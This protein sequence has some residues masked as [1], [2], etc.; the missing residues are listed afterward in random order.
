MVHVRGQWGGDLKIKEEIRRRSEVLNF[1]PHGVVVLAHDEIRTC[2]CQVDK[3]ITSMV[4]TEVQ[5]KDMFTCD[6][7]LKKPGLVKYGRSYIIIAT[8]AVVL[9]AATAVIFRLTL[10][11]K[12]EGLDKI[13]GVLTGWSWSLAL[14]SAL[15][16]I[17]TK[18]L[19]PGTTLRNL[20]QGKRQ[21]SDLTDMNLGEG[22][23]ILFAQDARTNHLWA[24][25]NACAYANRPCGTV[26]VSEMPSG[27]S[28]S[29]KLGLFITDKFAI[30][31]QQNTPLIRKTVEILDGSIH[32]EWDEPVEGSVVGRL[33]GKE[34][35]VG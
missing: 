12:A 25:G 15:I 17:V 29:W 33:L 34:V 4:Q 24:P 18:N 1:V 16:L 27:G 3:I 6:E 23:L 7:V 26:Q 21:A 22:A 19:I 8:Y 9:V 2:P 28:E 35:K 30:K 13:T 31:L 10:A 32:I 20:C 5:S 14:V 11:S